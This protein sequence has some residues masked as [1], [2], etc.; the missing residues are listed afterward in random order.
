MLRKF[1]QANF[2]LRAPLLDTDGRIVGV[3]NPQDVLRQQEVICYLTSLCYFVTLI[4]YVDSLCYFAMSICHISSFC[5][6]SFYIVTLFRHLLLY[7]TSS[8]YF[9]VLVRDFVL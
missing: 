8:Y 5:L 3:I 6:L 7:V 2:A 1:R 4:R 9:L